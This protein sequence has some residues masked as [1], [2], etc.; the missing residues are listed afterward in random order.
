M[1]HEGATFEDFQK[2]F[3]R[4]YSNV[5]C[6][7]QCPEGWCDIVWRLSEQLE[8]LGVQCDQVKE[9]FGGL[10]FYTRGTEDPNDKCIDD[11]IRAAE[12]EAARTCD[13]CGK[14]GQIGKWTE[15]YVR[16][17]CPEHTPKDVEHDVPGILKGEPLAWPPSDEEPQP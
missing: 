15:H 8:P 13:I 14:P 16:A 6:G 10:R 11:L 1:N 2:A 5:R 17:M 9:K 7:F 4:L 3:P 12:H